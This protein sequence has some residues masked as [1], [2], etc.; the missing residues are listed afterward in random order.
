MKI[1][2]IFTSFA[3]S[4]VGRKFYKQILHPSKDV[5]L[6]NHLPLLESGIVT[7][8]YCLSTAIQKDIPPENKKSIQIQNLLSF[9][10]STAT[11][12][13]LN[14]KASKFGEKIIKYLNPE[15]IPNSHKIIDG[16]RVGI[17]M[18]TTLLISRFL[19]AVGL[20]P[21]S[22]AIRKKLDVKV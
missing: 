6:N 13:P 18:I 5:F 9:L 3:K 8:F 12:I 14:K 16:I 15:V 4:N 19:V 20:V 21:L 22:T 10:I 1:N 2:N 7:G 11:A 17:P